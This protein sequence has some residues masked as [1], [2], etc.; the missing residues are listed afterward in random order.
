MPYSYT[1]PK[2][3]LCQAVEFINHAEPKH[4]S[5]WATDTVYVLTGEAREQ[6]F[7]DLVEAV[8][9]T[10]IDVTLD[11]DWDTKTMRLIM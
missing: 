4:F 5:V 3:E 9:Q 10:A 6:T 7:M 2:E 11:M 8:A 1:F